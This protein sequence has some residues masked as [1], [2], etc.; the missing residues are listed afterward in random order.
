[1]MVLMMIMT[2]V[3]TMIIKLIGIGCQ[4]TLVMSILTVT[5]MIVMI[6]TFMKLKAGNAD[7]Y[8]DNKAD[9]DDETTGIEE[10]RDGNEDDNDGEMDIN[11]NSFMDNER[12]PLL[13]DH[14]FISP[15]LTFLFK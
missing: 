12:T 4:R 2:M 1:M 15:G 5:M 8:D 13:R 7:D 9:D 14:I 6:R 3:M 10:T 11:I